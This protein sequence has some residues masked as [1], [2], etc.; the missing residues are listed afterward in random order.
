MLVY[1]E[2]VLVDTSNKVIGA[3]INIDGETKIL[4]RNEIVKFK[5]NY[6]N[7]SNAIIT[8]NGFVK[9]K[10]GEKLQREELVNHEM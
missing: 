2:K 7:F 9:A 1:V 10:K 6:G 5:R 4:N 8:Y 3:S